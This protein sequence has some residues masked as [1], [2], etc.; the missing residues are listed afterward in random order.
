M[1]KV[2]INE[3]DLIE[4]LVTRDVTTSGKVEVIAIDDN[5]FVDLNYVFY[6]VQYDSIHGKFN[7]IAKPE[8][9]KL[10]INGKAIFHEQDPT[11]IKWGDSGAK[12]VVGST[13]VFTTI[14]RPGPT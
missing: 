10:A 2:E 4:C 1:V 11:N 13:G 5:P 9:G 3:F 12:C 14:R 8:N 7:G 6:I